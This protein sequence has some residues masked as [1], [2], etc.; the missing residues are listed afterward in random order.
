MHQSA[1]LDERTGS[2]QRFPHLHFV[3]KKNGVHID[4]LALKMDGVR[5]LPPAD[6]DAFAR[7]R[8]D[9][10]IVIDGVALPS[11]ADVPEPEENEDKDMHAE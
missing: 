4:P 1:A 11:A 8:A 10:D 6:R 3:V 7:K 9:L 5:V 2:K